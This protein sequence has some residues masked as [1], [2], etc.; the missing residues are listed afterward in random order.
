M[1]KLITIDGVKFYLSR[2]ALKRSKTRAISKDLIIEALQ[3]N[4]S[5]LKQRP[6]IPWGMFRERIYYKGY[7]IVIH[8]RRIVTV[9]NRNDD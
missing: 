1:S 7:I 9:I 4:I 3:A 6:S 2:H 5:T 8:G